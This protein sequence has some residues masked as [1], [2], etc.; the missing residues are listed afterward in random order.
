[1]S[2]GRVRLSITDARALAEGALRAVGLRDDEAQI[3]ADH[4]IDAAMCGYEYSGL[5]KILNVVESEHFRSPRRSMKVL[6]KTEVSLAFDGGNR[7][8]SLSSTLRILARPEYS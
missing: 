3:I 5:G 2:S 1:M 4:V 8:C 7:K 6:R